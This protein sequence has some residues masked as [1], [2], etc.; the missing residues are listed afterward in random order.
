MKYFPHVTQ[1]F[2]DVFY[3]EV[4]SSMEVKKLQLLMLC[5]LYL[6]LFIVYFKI[7]QT[8]SWKITLRINF[9]E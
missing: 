4:M 1:N 8:C 2:V 9:D 6:D 3:T 5:S 7:G